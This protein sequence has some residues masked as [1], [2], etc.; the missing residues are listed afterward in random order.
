MSEN[1]TPW[2]LCNSKTEFQSSSLTWDETRKQCMDIPEE[3]AGFWHVWQET[4]PAWKPLTEVSDLHS[5]VKKKV[6]PPPRPKMSVPPPIPKAPP[7]PP[8]PS[9]PEEA[10]AKFNIYHA[11]EST[12]KIPVDEQTPKIQMEVPVEKIHVEKPPERVARDSHGD[13]KRKFPRFEIRLRI[14]IRNA[15][16]TF[17][18]FSK[19]ISLTGICLEHA[20]PEHLFESGCHIFIASPQGSENLRFEL[21]PTSRNDL[22]YFSFSNLD[23][24]L[25]QKLSDWL[26]KHAKVKGTGAA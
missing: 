13:K 5:L 26:E 17:R 25:T 4:W 24:K 15:Q 23:D 10:T 6:L 14:I 2:Y 1:G 20:I 9:D 11:E 3:E 12:Q 16:M 7:I 8:L 22:R 18:T 19:D 21:G